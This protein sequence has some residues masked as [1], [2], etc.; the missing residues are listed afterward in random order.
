MATLGAMLLIANPVRAWLDR[1][2]GINPARS[3][4]SVI[5]LPDGMEAITQ[6]EVVVA[7]ETYRLIRTDTAWR[8]DTAQ[9]F[10]VRADRMRALLVGLDELSWAQPRTQDPRK[11]DAIGLGDPREGG[12]GALI[13]LHGENNAQVAQ[14]IAGRRDERLYAR[15]HDEM[16]AW[17]VDG[18]LP[19]LHGRDGWLD[20]A[21]LSMQPE[22]IGAVLIAPAQGEELL[23]GAQP[24]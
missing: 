21:V 16:S 10:P 19:P 12:N 4:E 15:R 3:G 7:D 9:G 8:M 17:R 20:F 23:L 11:F 24:W 22:T 2:A 14:L 5:T 1:P 18:K 13:I 6:I